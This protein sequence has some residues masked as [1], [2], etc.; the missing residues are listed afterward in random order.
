M[1]SNSPSNRSISIGGNVSGSTIIS[2]DGNRV[3]T[4]TFQSTPANGTPERKKILVL[5]SNPQNSTRQRLDEEVR[6]ITEGLKRARARDEFEITQRWAVRPRDFQRAMLDESP[7]IVHFAGNTA[8]NKAGLYFEDVQGNPQPVADSALANLFK[9]FATKNK[10]DCVVLNGCYSETQAVAIAQHIPYVVGIGQSVSDR[11][12][13]EFSVGFYDALG[14]GE[15][16]DFAFELGKAAM[17]MA[18]TGDEEP[19]ILLTM[20]TAASSGQLGRSNSSDRPSNPHPNTPIPITAREVFISYAWGGESETI[21]N[22]LDQSFQ[23]Q[24]IN[25]IRD[26]KDAGYKANIRD[27]MQQIGQ[28]KCVLVVISDK[29][30]ISENCMFELVEIANSGDFYDRIFPIVL[31]DAN[32]YKAA[33]R[34]KYKRYWEQQK[35]ELE[36]EIKAGGITNLQGITDDLDLYDEICRRVPELTDILKNMNTLT[37][38]MHR[39]SNFDVV[40]E[41]VKAKLAE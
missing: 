24:G 19:P 38:E 25:I 12:A 34:L 8:A 23:S 14:N 4:S 2:G 22:Q 1:S 31:S 27:F 11:A 35:N 28:G 16:L 15:T 7:Q 39:D 33:A 6:D 17:A 36:T 13:I 40:I 29:Y 20:A 32:I 30:L 5:A 9:L 3:N 41:A 18:G 26:K 10:I 37:S 21:A